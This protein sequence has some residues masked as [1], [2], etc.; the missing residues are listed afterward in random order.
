MTILETIFKQHQVNWDS[1]IPFGFQ[2]ESGNF[3]YQESIMN[4]DFR[5]HVWID[6]N[7]IVS[8]RVIDVDL[9]E[10][11]LSIDLENSRNAFVNQ[12]Q[13][14][15]RKVLENI[16]AAC[17]THL[18]FGSDQMN[19]IYHCLESAFGDSY[20]YP[21]EKVPD[22]KAFRVAGKWY[23][24]V[25]H[26]EGKKLQGYEGLAKDR[27]LEVVNL[28][29]KPEHLAD[30]LDRDGIYPAYHMSKKSW[31]TVVLDDS[32]P[33]QD[34]ISLFEKSRALV[35]PSPLSNGEGP[36]YW[37]IPANLK[38]YDIDAEFRASKEI[39]WTQKASIKAGDYLLIYITAPTKA[40]RYL[41]RVTESDISNQGY[42]RNTSIKSLMRIQLLH[43]FPDDLLT[44]EV[45]KDHDVRAVR[46]P[47]RITP[48]LIAFLKEKGYLKDN[49]NKH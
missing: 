27:V 1:L 26:V 3:H 15:Y 38:Y 22:A 8:T 43:Q 44:F 36:D 6:H 39:L 31:V 29:V 25:M 42:R 11:Y 45:M 14:A 37:V 13:A 24:L 41:C 30:L 7:G 40:I 28:K 47:R 18:P 48:Q 4:G 17:F 20:D 5:V 46:G 21:F 9:D 19:R 23:A 32:L 2:K 12:V 34:L 10:D 35:N 16:A 33:D 49:L